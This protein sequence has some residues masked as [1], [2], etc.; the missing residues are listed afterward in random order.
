MKLASLVGVAAIAF[1]LPYTAGAAVKKTGTWPKH[2]PKVDLSFDGKPSEGLKRLAKEAEWSLVVSDGVAM[3][4]ANVHVDVEDQPADAVL[5][6]LFAGHDVVAAR[7]GSLITVVPANAPH[8]ADDPFGERSTSDFPPMPPVPPVPPMPPAPPVPPVQHKP[9]EEQ[10]TPPLPAERGED[11]DIYGGSLVVKE[12]EVVHTAT[13][14]GGSARIEGTVTGDLI[15]AGGSATIAS[16]GRVVGDVTVFGGSAHVEDGGRIDGDV[17]VAGGSVHRDDGGAIGGSVDEHGGKKKYHEASEPP[18]HASTFRD[19]A[20]SAAQ[21]VG[22]ALTKSALL[23]VF[24]CILLALLAPPMERIRVEVAARPMRS[25]AIGLVGSL[26]SAIGLTILCTLLCITVIGIPVALVGLM[27]VILAVYGAAASVLTTVGAA[28]L[29]HRTQ[30]PYVH[31]LL[32]CAV[33]LV[34]SAIPVVG[35]LVTIALVSV[36]VGAL[37]ATR[38]GG[39]LDRTRRLPAMV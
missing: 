36:A 24:G 13:V 28:L 2:E 9:G 25:F 5:D 31:L 17:G 14:T 26:A 39:L 6:A 7:K 30:S 3:D 12:G 19:R 11:R 4:G 21:S 16:G 1:L 23:F 18:S 37:L 34:L 20:A 8:A 10:D 27:L 38:A 29:G 22:T 15:V 32:G 33:L 35:V